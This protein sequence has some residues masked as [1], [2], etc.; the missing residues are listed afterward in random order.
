[1][2]KQAVRLGFEPCMSEPKLWAATCTW[3][4]LIWLLEGNIL[5][6]GSRDMPRVWTMAR[7]EQAAHSHPCPPLTLG[8]SWHEPGLASRGLRGSRA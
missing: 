7:V 8:H 4:F 6:E 2:P 1:M 3:A 5:C